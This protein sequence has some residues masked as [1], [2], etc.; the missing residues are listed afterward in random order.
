MGKLAR[1]SHD[2]ARDDKKE[3]RVAIARGNYPVAG[4]IRRYL[5]KNFSVRK[6]T[7]YDRVAD[8]AGHIRELGYFLFK[9]RD[10]G[11]KET[12]AE[13]VARLSLSEQDIQHKAIAFRRLAYTFILFAC[14][15]IAYAIYSYLHDAMV[16]AV[17]SAGVSSLMWAN[18]FRFH[19]WFFQTV[20]RRLGCSMGE[21][22]QWC[23]QHKGAQS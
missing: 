17:V 1:F 19:F 3:I 5:K 23:F 15:M 8:G 12:F 6:M 10:A 21:W 7:D 22:L 18:A 2:Y 11:R 16:A 9:R 4:R 13:A 14:L 20:Q